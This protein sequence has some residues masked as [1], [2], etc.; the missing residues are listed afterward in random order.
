MNQNVC[1]EIIAIFGSFSRGKGWKNKKGCTE[2]IEFL[3]DSYPTDYPEPEAVIL[4]GKKKFKLNEVPVEMDDRIGGKSSISGLTSIYYMIKV[5]LSIL[6]EY[7]RRS[8]E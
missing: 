2:A 5:I 1:Y 7:V 6:I 4:L 3:K 8:D